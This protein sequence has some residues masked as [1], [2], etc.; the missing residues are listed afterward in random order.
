M[1]ISY[2]KENPIRCFFAFE[3]YNSQGM[4]LERLKQTYPSFDWICA[5]RSE[6]DKYAIM[7]ANAVFPESKDKNFGDI[8]KI[9]WK[10]VPDFDLFT[11]SFPCTDISSAGKQ[12]GLEENSGTR[13]SLLWE[14]KK[15]IEIK[16]PEF[17]LMENVKALTQ[18]KF[19]PYLREWQLWLESKGYS[20]YTK[21]LN[22]K[23]YGVPQNRERVFMVSVLHKTYYEFPRPFKLEK[24]LKDVLETETG[25][26]YIL[27]ERFIQTMLRRNEENKKKG[28]GFAFIVCTGEDIAAVVKTRAGSQME[29][30]FIIQ[31]GNIIEEKNFDNP[32]I[33]R[34]YSINGISPTIDTMQRGNAQPK[35]LDLINGNYHI[36]KLTERECFRLMG[37]SD[38]DIT[39]IQETGVSRTQQYKMADNSIVVDVLYYIFENLFINGNSNKGQ[40]YLF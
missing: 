3:G 10:D 35:I 33:G 24:R 34:V 25:K 23:D 2:T 18:K 5:G 28:N 17:L 7:A 36:R 39:K 40:L 4:A 29:D 9:E 14:C 11:Y 22:A 26:E 15:A 32:Q 6:I 1:D 30:N 19:L 12:K 31:V 20:N 21:V 38:T 16:R 27:S 37:V 13:S 8:S